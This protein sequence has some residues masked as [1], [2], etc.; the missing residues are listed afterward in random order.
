MRLGLWK[1][2]EWR[3]TRKALKEQREIEDEVILLPDKGNATVVMRR[4]NFNNKL[5]GML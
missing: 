2:E 5:N 3:A 4:E 1:P